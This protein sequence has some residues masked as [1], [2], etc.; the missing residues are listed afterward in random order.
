MVAL[1]STYERTPEPMGLYVHVP[2]CRHRCSYCDFFSLTDVDASRWRRTADGIVREIEA[3]SARWNALGLLPRPLASVF[4]GGGTPSW[5]PEPEL[6]RIVRA[7]L[8]VF[9]GAKSA[10]WTLETN[11]ETVDEDFGR[12]LAD[13]PF[14]RVSLGVQSFRQELLDRLDRRVDAGAILRALER[15]RPHVPRLSVDLIFGIPGQTEAAVVDDVRRA[16]ALGTE[17]LSF[18]QL[19]LK[20]GHPLYSGL[21]SDDESAELYEAGFAAMAESGFERYEVSNFAKPGA[22]CEH[23]WLYWSGGAYLGVGPSA[24]GR[25]FDGTTFRHRKSFADWN[26]WMA[27]TE[28]RS[29]SPDYEASTPWQS[30]LEAL[31]AEL[32]TPA[33]VSANAFATRYRWRLEAS[34]RFEQL[35]REGLITRDANDGRIRPTARGMLLADGLAEA[36]APSAEEFEKS[37]RQN[38]TS[39]SA[40]PPARSPKAGSLLPPAAGPPPKPPAGAPAP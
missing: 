15:L 17:H 13:T 14:R 22:L 32:R 35:C 24:S 5:M 28:D 16:T 6:R 19:T 40:M 37:V 7:I 25:Y 11:P 39:S 8:D 33:G 3:E 36:L 31:L 1:P 21:P 20:P 9:P 4:F 30:V 10:E 26:R 18:Y 23:N 38:G 29:L 27:S 12:R 2:F 34:S